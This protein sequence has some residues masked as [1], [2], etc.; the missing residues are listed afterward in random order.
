MLKDYFLKVIL[1]GIITSENVELNKRRAEKLKLD[2]LRSGCKDKLSEIKK[3]CEEY[4]VALRNVCYIGDDI[5]DLEA[6]KAVGY[7]C[8]PAD[9][10]QTVK[11]S[12][13]YVTSVKGGDGVIREVVEKIIK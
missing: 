13:D 4:Q 9:A 1:T 2:I 8:C 12:A 7:G 5:N 3:L 6:I 11:Q 10:V